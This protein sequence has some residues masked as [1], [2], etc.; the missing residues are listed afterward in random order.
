MNRKHKNIQLLLIALLPLVFFACN[1]TRKLV[2]DEFLLQKNHIIDKDTKI[3]KSEFESYIK[4]KPNRKILLVFRFHLWLHNLANE[5]KIREKRILQDKKAEDKNNRRI[6]KGK[7][8]K[9]T[10]DNY[11]V[12]GC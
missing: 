8:P 1:P 4:Q 7:K 11:L 10:T 12:N 2:K 3:D 6:A 9:K 5:D